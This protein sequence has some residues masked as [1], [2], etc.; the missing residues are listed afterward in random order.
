MKV[1]IKTKLAALA[2]FSVISSM[3]HAASV[4]LTDFASNVAVDALNWTAST[5]TWSGTQI[6]GT[7][8]NEGTG[9]FNLT[10]ALSTSASNSSLLQVQ[11]TATVNSFTAGSFSITLENQSSEVIVADFAWDDFVVGS[12]TTVTKNFVGAS[13]INLATWNRSSVPNWNLVSSG[14]STPVNVTFSELSVVPEPSTGALMMIGA[15][16]LVALRRLRKV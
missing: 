10:S 1:A 6:V 11:V 8:Y 9:P 2:V 13:G 15:A 14:N 4:L 5:R 12:A 3:S 16:G 7:L